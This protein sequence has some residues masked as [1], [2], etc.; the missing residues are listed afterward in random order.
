[1]KRDRTQPDGGSDLI[2]SG[3][4]A[5]SAAPG[6]GGGASDAGDAATG[7]DGS[8]RQDC[9][10]NPQPTEACPEICPEACN[11]L[12]DDCDGQTDESQDADDSCAAPH[13]ESVC[14]SGQCLVTQCLAGYRD[15]DQ[16]ALTGCEVAP[17]DVNH[18]GACGHVCRIADASAVCSNGVCVVGSCDSGFAD[19]DHDGRTCETNTKTLDDCGGC[20]VACAN[21][22]NAVPSCAT[23]SCAVGSCKAGFG[24]CDGDPKN[25]CEQSLDTLQHCGGCNLACSKASCGGGVCTAADCSAMPGRADCDG[26]EA[27]CEID[28]RSDPNNCGACGSKCQFSA[29]VTPHATL[30]CTA[31][32]CQANC[33]A[34]Y[35]DCDGNYANGCEQ[36]LNTL[37]HCGACR[38]GCSIANATASCSTGSCQVSTCNTDWADCDSDKKSCETQLNSPSHCGSCTT[39]CNLPNA[40]E[41]CGGSAGARVCT[42]ASCDANWG[43]CDGDVT[44]GCERDVRTPANGGL[45]PCLPDTGCVKSVSG[46]NEYYVCPTART[47]T[48]ARSKCQL[49]AR[50]DLV[51]IADATENNFVKGKISSTVW[52]GHNDSAHEGVWVWSRNNVPFYQ[53][54]AGALPGQYSNFA[55]GEPNASGNC[56]AFYTSGQ[57]DDDN[58]SVS[59]A[60]VCEVMPD[61]CPSDASKLDPGQCGCGVVDLDS[62]GDGFADCSESCDS[63]PNKRVAGACGCGTPDTDSDGDGTPN[64]TDG[65]PSDGAKTT[66]GACGCGVSDA[67]SDG[68]GTRDCSESCDNDPAKT[69]PGTC[70]CGTPDTDSDGDGAANCVDGCPL[71]NSTPSACFSFT[72][73]NFSNNGLNYGAAPTTT[74]NCGTTTINSSNANPFSNW[75]GT[76]PSFSIQTQT[77]GPDI[78]VIPL[79]GL[80]ISSGA[81]LRLLGSRPV[82]F[83]VRGNVLVDGIIDANASGTTPGAGGN[84][85]CGSSAGG[86][87]SGSSAF[88]QGGGGGG[89]GAFGTAGGRGGQGDSNNNYGSGGT[90]RNSTNIVPLYGGCPGG[91]GGGCA[92]AGGAGGGAVQITASGSLTVNGTIRA[93]GAN[94]ANGCDTEGGGAGGGSGGAILLEAPTRTT[95]GTCAANGGSGGDGNGL[96]N[97]GGGAGSTSS[98]SSGNTGGNA[99]GAGGGGGGGFGRIKK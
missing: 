9:R 77:N 30:G 39:V 3:P 6:E 1:M 27:S 26:D 34:G 18:C 75:C 83:A 59:R 97:G 54:G 73:S 50:G 24:D 82:V 55:G 13:S 40:V 33:D 84:W 7:G 87:G 81:T 46:Q 94:G 79:K 20:G 41:G 35:G 14:Q 67:D 57:F 52:A 53:A 42:I 8:V 58:C 43:N 32:G 76:L 12:D 85:S 66:P 15:C 60:F 44:N 37:N 68:D 69:S 61:A 49:Q 17:E 29:G 72:H 92:A 65:C 45:G 62:D 86:N 48:D 21:V 10:E 96:S 25:G 90:A 56:G 47:W 93:N 80:T 11:G 36:P 31:S 88:L 28:L 4:D 91:N 2:D 70:G 23:G 38:T 71:D 64:C 19:C 98:A 74:L 95:P 51:Q 78:L 5:D 99:S 22:P 63:D 89:G 16:T